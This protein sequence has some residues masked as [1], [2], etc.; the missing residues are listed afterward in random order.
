M[1][2]GLENLVGRV[3]PAWR[4][5]LEIDPHRLVHE[6]NYP[7]KSLFAEAGVFSGTVDHEPLVGLNDSHAEHEIDH[8][9]V[10]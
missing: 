8:G 7:V 4:D 2:F 3:F 5:L 1:D 9:C 10:E 6:W